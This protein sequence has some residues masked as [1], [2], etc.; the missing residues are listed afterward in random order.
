M[1]QTE[2][3]ENPAERQSRAIKAALTL[4]N[5]FDY[6]FWEQKCNANP[7]SEMFIKMNP[8]HQAIHTLSEYIC[9]SQ[10]FEVN[11]LTQ[12]Y[13]MQKLCEALLFNLHLQG[14]KESQLQIIRT[15]NRKMDEL[16]LKC[17]G[18]CN[19]NKPLAIKYFD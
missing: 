6:I 19:A 5:E 1:G 17:V 8:V 11:A 9:R 4:N 13:M 10:G 14:E 12:G 16:F 2:Y 15:G 3:K 7:Q 18:I